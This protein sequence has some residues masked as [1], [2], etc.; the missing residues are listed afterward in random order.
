VKRRTISLRTEERYVS[1]VE[2]S[3]ATNRAGPARAVAA[4][5]LLLSGCASVPPDAGN[6]PR[7]PFERF[8]RQ[9][10]AFNDRFDRY[11][12]KPAAEGYV[13]VVPAAFRQCIA[14][15]FSN[16][17]EIGT[18]VNDILQAKPAGAGT[19]TGRLAI[20]TT[21][22]VFGCF[23]VASRIGLK[24]RT[25]D[26]GLTLARWGLG[27][28]P[29]LVLPVLGPSNVRDAIGLVPDS[30][31]NPISYVKP[32]KARYFLYGAYLIDRRALLLDATD[33]IDQ[34]ALDRYQFTRDAYIQNRTSLEYEGNPPLAP[35]HD[36]S[37][38]TGP[39]ADGAKTKPAEPPPEN[40]R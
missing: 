24:R 38:E 6:N 39:G 32:V 35:E 8:N 1:V 11:L 4:A 31:A 26:F 5:A 30:Y 15:A 3:N 19:D 23:D 22:G 33:L 21:L 10:F 9:T 16:V 14:N 36:D 27:T 40:Q 18:A 20:N 17:G 29:Y 28:G 7:D 25:E 12:V 13:A 2:P 37:G 34:A